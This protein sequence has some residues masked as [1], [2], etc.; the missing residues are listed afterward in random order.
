MCVCLSVCL[1]YVPYA[2]PEFWANLHDIWHV[3]FLYPTDGHEGEGG[4]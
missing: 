2:R 1:I 4:G 3:A